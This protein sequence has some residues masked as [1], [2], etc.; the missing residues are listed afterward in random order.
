MRGRIKT[1]PRVVRVPNVTGASPS[2]PGL[3]PYVYDHVSGVLIAKRD[4]V[5][6]RGG[7][8]HKDWRR[9]S[10]DLPDPLGK[11]R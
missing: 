7:W 1:K 5:R 6:Q 3:G 10:R 2:L 8:V 4:A 11:N 9:G